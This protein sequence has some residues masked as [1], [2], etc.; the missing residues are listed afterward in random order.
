MSES[1]TNVSNNHTLLLLQLILILIALETCLG[2]WNLIRHI[3]KCS[4]S[5]S[6]E[7]KNK[8]IVIEF[9]RIIKI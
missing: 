4:H 8:Q 7:N 6:M 3:K 5:F 1:Q 2:D 9:S